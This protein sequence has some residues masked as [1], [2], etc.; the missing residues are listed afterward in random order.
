MLQLLEQQ[1]P[2]SLNDQQ[3][4][5]QPLVSMLLVQTPPLMLQLLEQQQLVSLNDQL[6]QTQQLNHPDNLQ[7]LNS[8]SILFC[9][10]FELM[11]IIK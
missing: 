11:L 2:V 3:V 10:V 4:Q 9:F 6:A 8:K 7:A 5:V 1:Q